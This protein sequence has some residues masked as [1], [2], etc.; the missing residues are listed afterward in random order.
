MFFPLSAWQKVVEKER[1]VAG[2]F[3]LYWL[4]FMAL[5]T[6]AEGL[7]LV[8][9]G[10]AR[11]HFSRIML[12]SQDV[13][14]RYEARQWMAGLGIL[15]GGSAV[16]QWLAAGFHFQTTYT[17]CFTVVAYGLAPTMLARLLD[18]VPTLNTWL[19]WGLGALCSVHVLYQG[20]GAVLQP[21]ISGG[22]GLYLLSAFV[23]VFL[24]GMGHL[25]AVALLH[26]NGVF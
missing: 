12:V 17:R 2:I 19:C 22:F 6:A 24:T 8:Y 7:A 26:G 4:P 16:L 10:D 20:V 5:V 11:G 3:F 18:C 1:G 15:F 25:F 21:N 9:W 14:M 13:A 23:L